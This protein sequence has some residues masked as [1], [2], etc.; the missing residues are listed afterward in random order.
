MA[1]ALLV[2]THERADALGIPPDRRVYLR[3]WCGANDPVLVAEHPDLG[4]SPAMAAASAEALAR[5]GAGVDDVAYFDLYSCFPSSL[6]FAADVLR[7][8]P[9]DPRGL[10]VTG[11]LA[12]HGGP[13]SGYLTHS[14]AAMVDRLR[15]DAGALGLV[16]GVG[17][18]MTK[19]VFGCYSSEPGVVGRPN[20][21]GAPATRPVVATHEGG[22]RPAGRRA[23]LRDPHRRRRLQTCRAGGARGRNGAAEKR[24]RRR[25]PRSRHGQ[26]G[27]EA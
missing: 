7:M 13:A 22:L 27:E 4:S 15:A 6:H 23:H 5:A 18:H 2:A 16:S 19:H 21:V 11:G 1:A 8:D 12:Y 24:A 25:H 9:A 17:M 20:P 3:G 10:T 26:S 14:I